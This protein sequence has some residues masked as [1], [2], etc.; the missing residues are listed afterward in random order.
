MPRR[1]DIALT[2]LACLAFCAGSWYGVVRLILW[3]AS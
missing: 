2:R 1:L 3:V